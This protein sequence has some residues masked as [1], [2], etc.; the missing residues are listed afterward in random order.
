MKIE[1]GPV[2]CF[3]SEEAEKLEKIANFRGMKIQDVVAEMVQNFFDEV[4]NHPNAGKAE[5]E[6]AG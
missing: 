1:A 3:D 4:V 5:K 2:L 6:K